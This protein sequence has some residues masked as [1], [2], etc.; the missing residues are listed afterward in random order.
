MGHKK[1]FGQ[2][3]G[4]GVGQTFAP[5][6]MDVQRTL[7]RELLSAPSPEDT[8]LRREQTKEQIESTKALTSQRQAQA[9]RLAQSPSI[10]SKE[11]PDVFKLAVQGVM[12]APRAKLGL[13][14]DEEL[15]GRIADRF[16]VLKAARGGG[17]LP[18]EKLPSQKPK[19]AGGKAAPAGAQSE[20]IRV[21]LKSTGQTGTI[22]GKDFDPEKFERIE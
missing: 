10:L 8:D 2:R 11:D 12:A 3:F 16:A 7:L 1:S 21:R 14:N 15:N 18:Q 9:K 5:T 20:K 6:A 17:I 13:I 4:R 22:E 19:A